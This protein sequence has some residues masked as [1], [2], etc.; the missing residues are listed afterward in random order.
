MA[1]KKIGALAVVT[2]TNANGRSR[3]GTDGA[4]P[5]RYGVNGNDRDSLHYGTTR[6]GITRSAECQ[7]NAPHT[8]VDD[9]AFLREIANVATH[10]KTSSIDLMQL[11]ARHLEP[12]LFSSTLLLPSSD[13]LQLTHIRDI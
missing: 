11:L 2:C 5:S 7:H 13:N 1:P 12:F 4:S 8:V 10:V 9:P 3:Y 6:N